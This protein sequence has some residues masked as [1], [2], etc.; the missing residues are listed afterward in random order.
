MEKASCKLI[1]DARERNVLR[2]ESEIGEIN[3]EVKQITTGDYIVINGDRILA[4]MERKS[5]EDYAASLKD[6]RHSNKAK[7]L[8]MR[9]QTLCTV[10]YIV[11]GP[12]F[13]KPNDLFGNIPYRYIESSIFHLAMR[14]GIN[15]LRTKDTLHTAQM[16]VRFMQSM[17]N[18]V[19]K[20]DILEAIPQIIDGGMEFPDIHSLITARIVKADNEVVREMWSKYPGISVESADEYMKKWSLSD[21]ICGR[22]PPD[23]LKDLRMASGRRV[24][25][26]VMRGLSTL[27]ITMQVKLLSAIPSLSQKTAASVVSI[28]VLPK[29]LEMSEGAISSMKVGKNANLGPAK[30]QKILK[31]FN[32]K[33]PVK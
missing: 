19:A 9:A 24:S 15:I 2:H 30:A 12:E 10:F 8:E 1:I 13:P 18:L 33:Y 21:M 20:G 31:Y 11:E 5:L 14:D 4:V 32:F 3:H 22:V 27:P 17:D 7:L 23:E 29:L 25:A 26:K 6:G 16:L 28:A